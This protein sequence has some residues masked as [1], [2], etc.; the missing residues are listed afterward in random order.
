M[1][2]YVLCLFVDS[3]LATIIIYYDYSRLTTMTMTMT[4]ILCVLSFLS[5]VMHIPLDFDFAERW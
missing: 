5:F 4:T 2:I 1:Y 3:K